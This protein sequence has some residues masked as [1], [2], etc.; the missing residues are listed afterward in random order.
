MRVFSSSNILFCFV[1]EFHWINVW[2]SINNVLRFKD[3]MFSC[4]IE[5]DIFCLSLYMHVLYVM[6][7]G[8]SIC[9]R[10]SILKIKVSNLWKLFH[11]EALVHLHYSFPLKP[12]MKRCVSLNSNRLRFFYNQFFFYCKRYIFSLNKTFFVP[13]PAIQWMC[14]VD[15]WNPQVKHKVQLMIFR[16]YLFC[17]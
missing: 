10:F 17:Y 15:L 1:L 2:F 16:F 14:Q 3:Y 5:V 13:T 12:L 6:Q 4:I 7:I 8:F 9:F 11:F